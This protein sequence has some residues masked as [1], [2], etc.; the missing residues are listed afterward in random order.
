MTSAASFRKLEHR[1]HVLMRPDMYIGSVRTEP[2]AAWI[3]A[4]ASCNNGGSS[5]KMERR[6]DVAY[7][8]G[9]LKVF[10]EILVNAADHATRSRQLLLRADAKGDDDPLQVVKKIEVAIDAKSGVLEVANDGDGIPV[11]AH[12][13]GIYVPELIFGHLL[14]SANYDD[15][16]AAADGGGE[17]G[18][19]AKSEGSDKGGGKKAGGG[20]SGSKRTVGG[21]NGIGAKACNILSKWFEIEIV[22]RRRHLRYRQRWEDNMSKA[23]PA[24]IEKTTVKKSR[25]VVRWLPDYAR[26]S[27][28]AATAAATAAAANAD[29]SNNLLSPDMHALMAR[30][31]VDA[32][33]VTD[34]DVA[35]WLDGKKL[36]V[37]SFERYVEL[38]PGVGAGN[39]AH[40]RPCDG[41]E[42]A[43][44]MLPHDGRDEGMQQVSFVN[45]VATLRGGRH[46]DHVVQQMCKKVCEL[47]AARKKGVTPKPQY[48]RDNLI[49]FVR[50]TVPGP[51]FDSQSKE[52]LTTT[53]SHFG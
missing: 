37:K 46:V 11:E 30:R 2:M 41:W 25:T 52:T 19:D 32:C 12:A 13:S 45:G 50:A 16:E 22:D 1:E 31:V 44:A 40:E 53:P 39:K 23:L 18:D 21:Q 49:V 26:F 3:L 9:L 10:D 17:G 7:C 33:A 6:Q 35:V 36:E 28:S 42:V 47:I 43:A 24:R 38:F 15:E 8:P 14:T 34:P 20:G 51:T 4:D 27:S 48:V 5:A 29:A